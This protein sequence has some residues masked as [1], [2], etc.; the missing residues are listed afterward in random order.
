MRLSERLAKQNEKINKQARSFS[1]ED[2]ETMIYME[3]TS[4]NPINEERIG[5]YQ[6][7]KSLNR[8]KSIFDRTA[9]FHT[10]NRSEN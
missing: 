1:E 9:L 2:E 5:F 8:Q 3:R 4:V 7:D 10:E 6:D